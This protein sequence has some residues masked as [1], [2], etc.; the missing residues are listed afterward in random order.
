MKIMITA[1]AV[2]SLLYLLELLLQVFILV[3]MVIIIRNFPFCP[4]FPVLSPNNHTFCILY[5]E[6]GKSTSISPHPRLL[7]S[8]ARPAILSRRQPG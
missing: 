2:L 3:S 4:D 6:C 1:M 5:A 7:K 8:H